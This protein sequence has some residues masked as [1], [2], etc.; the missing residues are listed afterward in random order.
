MDFLEK[1]FSSYPFQI[2]KTEYAI[3]SLLNSII[4]DTSFDEKTSEKDSLENR[5]V[6]Q[7]SPAF[8]SFGHFLRFVAQ[9]EGDM[10]SWEHRSHFRVTLQLKETY[11]TFFAD[12]KCL[13]P[14]CLNS[15]VKAGFTNSDGSRFAHYLEWLLSRFV[16]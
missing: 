4:S 8:P 5:G 3:I 9:I 2:S 16:L 7:C 10:G 6:I 12:S 13:G 1:K 11:L 15:E 14:I